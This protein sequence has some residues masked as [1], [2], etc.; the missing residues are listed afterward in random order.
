MTKK[1]PIPVRIVRSN[2]ITRSPE[3]GTSRLHPKKRKETADRMRAL[4]LDEAI[5][6]AM[7]ATGLL[8][9]KQN[10]D[11][12]PASQQEEWDKAIQEA[13]ERIRG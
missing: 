3:G 7:E 1:N 2:S 11:K 12:L 4:G 13:R 5:C 10:Y 8:V 9:T 6:Q